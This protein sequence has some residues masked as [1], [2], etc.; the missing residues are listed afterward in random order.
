LTKRA[1]VLAHYHTRGLLRSDTLAL[2]KAGLERC[3]RVILI[4]TKLQNAQLT[5][6]PQGIEVHV[7]NNTGYDFYS[8]RHGILQVLNGEGAH[9]LPDEICL[10]N[11][12]FVCLDAAGFLDR[13]F[14]SAGDQVDC[15]GLVRSLEVADHIQS[16]VIVLSRHVLLDPAVLD[17]WTRMVPIDER[18]VVI[19]EY[20]IGLSQLLL[21]LGYQLKPAYDHRAC[22]T[23]DVARLGREHAV[24]VTTLNVHLNPSHFHWLNLLREFSTLKIEVYRNNPFRLDLQPLMQ[25]ARDELSVRQLL[26]EG[27]QT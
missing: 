6:L 25:L 18:I 21:R 5:R 9:G 17:W 10:M 23:A 26:E 11:S 20:E 16:Y 7:R 3:T 2:L 1:L 24:D 22:I 14:R 12:S 15:Y 27:L 4:S 13:L 19:R 8:Y